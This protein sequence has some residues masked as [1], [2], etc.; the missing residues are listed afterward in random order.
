MLGRIIQ[1]HSRRLT[2]KFFVAIN[3]ERKPR[4]VVP[5][6]KNWVELNPGWDVPS[7]WNLNRGSPLPGC[8][9][10]GQ[11]CAPEELSA[12]AR[13][14]DRT[15]EVES[16]R[17]NSRG[18]QSGCP[19]FFGHKRSGDSL[20]GRSDEASRCAGSLPQQALHPDQMADPPSVAELLRVLHW[21]Q[22][23]AEASSERAATWRFVGPWAGAGARRLP[24]TSGCTGEG[25]R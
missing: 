2:N 7:V 21:G 5:R 20:G 10:S 3:Y 25:R 6:Q 24:T 17:Q 8:P 16:G 19:A 15:M 22:S 9:P 18:R 4:D 1:I 14:L 11:L 13:S 23:I 12:R